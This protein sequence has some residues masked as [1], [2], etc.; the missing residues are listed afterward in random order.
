MFVM[1]LELGGGA[2]TSA[3]DLQLGLDAAL[4][5]LY[6]VS[7]VGC[8]YHEG[9]NAYDH[10]RSKISSEAWRKA[11][12]CLKK[13]IR[14]GV[15]FNPVVSVTHVTSI[16]EPHRPRVKR[17]PFHRE[18]CRKKESIAHQHFSARQSRCLGCKECTE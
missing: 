1:P 17:I 5:I 14:D 3:G 12:F 6:D 4:V 9:G 7:C 16:S 11:S 18:S 2:V 8:F 10:R 15:V 13:T